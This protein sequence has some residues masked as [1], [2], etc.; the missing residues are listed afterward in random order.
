VATLLLLGEKSY[1]QISSDTGGVALGSITKHPSS[2]VFRICISKTMILSIAIHLCLVVLVFASRSTVAKKD[3]DFCLP[4]VPTWSTSAAAL[5]EP[6][7]DGRSYPSFS[8]QLK[9]DAEISFPPHS[10]NRKA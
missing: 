5:S 3:L 10:V 6:L 7:I 4:R 8:E 9:L 2:R 1:R